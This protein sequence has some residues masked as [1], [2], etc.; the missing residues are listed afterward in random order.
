[1]S[2]GLEERIR[3]RGMELGFERV[4]FSPAARSPRAGA[5]LRWLDRGF[6]GEME[7]MRREPERRSDVTRRSPWVRTVI[8]VS[9]GYGSPVGPA[10]RPDASSA[11]RQEGPPE[12]PGLSSLVSRYALG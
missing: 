7:Y 8:S 1:M 2:P 6:A 11:L 10:Y 5:F 9:L 3:A 4:V 12:T